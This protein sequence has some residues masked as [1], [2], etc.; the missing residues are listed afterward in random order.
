LGSAS[1]ATTGS[2]G[3]VDSSSQRYKPFGELRVAGSGQPSKYTFTGHYDFMAFGLIDMQARMYSPILGR[4]VSADTIVPR[5]N[6][7]QALNR[8]SY[9]R[10]SPLTR[11]D[12]D[13]HCDGEFAGTGENCPGYQG[14]DWLGEPA[15]GPIDYHGAL[16]AVGL[17]PVV[18]EVADGINTVAYAAEGDWGNAAISAVAVVPVVGDAAKAG[19]IA[20]KVAKYG[21][22]VVDGAK[23]V[24]EFDIV[25][26]GTKA[27]GFEKHHAVPDAWAAANLKNY[28]S[29]N[30]QTPTIVLSGGNHKAATQVLTDFRT[31]FKGDW[32]SASPAQ[33]K[34]VATQSMNAANVPVGSQKQYWKQWNKYVR[35]L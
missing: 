3:I 18:G 26:Y 29:R 32:K 35:E 33:I 1:L 11:I 27:S 16:D 28:T 4:F 23:V 20:S 7:P 17:V 10:N 24:K 8:F 21:D 19:R 2:G 14:Q 15:Q 5:V 12:P 34:K 6:D 30:T 9:V 22:E 25:S 13:G 31:N